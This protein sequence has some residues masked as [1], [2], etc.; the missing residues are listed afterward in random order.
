MLINT[1]RVLGD[2][3]TGP[4]AFRLADVRTAKTVTCVV[5]AYTYRS[6][7]VFASVYGEESNSTTDNK[8]GRLTGLFTFCVGT[9][10]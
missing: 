3:L 9:A 7:C 1:E 8:E 10:F 2:K 5:C 4:S 6:A